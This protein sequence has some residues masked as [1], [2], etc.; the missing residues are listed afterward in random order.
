MSD[1]TDLRNIGPRSSDWLNSVGIRT[2]EDL[3]EIGI[4]EAYL[5]TKKAYPDR[6]SL[7]LLYGLQAAMLDID[8][9]H[10]PERMKRDLRN[11]VG[12]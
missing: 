12:K 4:V 9:K 1:L 11:Q 6:V 10:L 3:E 7:N 8:W 2:V 5:R